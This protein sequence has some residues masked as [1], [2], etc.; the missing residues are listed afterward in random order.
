VIIP[1]LENTLIYIDA[2]LDELEREEFS[3][4][5]RVMGVGFKYGK[6]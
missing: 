4:R 2:E 3:R 1:R 5:K 6:D